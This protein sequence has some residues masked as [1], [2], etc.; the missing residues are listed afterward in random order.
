[1]HNWVNQLANFDKKNK[2]IQMGLFQIVLKL[3]NV[4]QELILLGNSSEML[5]DISFR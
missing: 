2:L 5:V 1:M 3:G 4:I